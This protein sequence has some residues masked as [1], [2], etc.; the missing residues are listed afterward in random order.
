MRELYS[1]RPAT[2]AD[3]DFLWLAV[4]STMQDY[5][6]AIWGWD[7]DWQQHRFRDNFQNSNW[8]IIR[9]DV[10]DVGGLQFYARPQEADLFLSNIH[11]LAKFQ[12]RGI[13]TAI[14]RDLIA[15]A[16]ATNIPLTLNVLKSNPDA[17]RL[18]Q[19][20]GLH[21]TAENPERYFM[22]SVVE[23]G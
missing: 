2:P 14:V 22:S 15:Q 12:G 1:L 6:T 11:I 8:Q 4:K 18:Y 13:G 21:V 20:L 3:Y 9:V 17:L 16:V 5:V 19:R 7:E 10:I 23:S